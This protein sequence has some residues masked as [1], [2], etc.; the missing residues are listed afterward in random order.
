[1]LGYRVQKNGLL[2]EVLR[3]VHKFIQDV[4]LVV[5]DA[6]EVEPVDR[7]GEELPPGQIEDLRYIRF[8][9]FVDRHS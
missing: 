9:S 8:D 1:M 4:Q 2:K 5:I 7:S 6:R 3:V